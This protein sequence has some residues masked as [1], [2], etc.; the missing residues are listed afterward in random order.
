MAKPLPVGNCRI[1]GAYGPLSFEHVPPRSAF[2]SRPILRA[3][4]EEIERAEFDV[5]NVRGK[6]HQRGSGGHTL[7]IDCNQKTGRW[8]GAAF[9]DW[10]HGAVRLL[11][12]PLGVASIY[13]PFFIFP[14][15]V[16]K[17]ILCMFA[18]RT[19]GLFPDS[20]PELRTFVLDRDVRGLNPRFQVF[21]Y[22]NVSNLFRTMGVTI[23]G[24]LRTHQISKL[25][26]ISFPPFGYVLTIDSPPPDPRL[27]EITHF[28]RYKYDEWRDVWLRMPLL[29]VA[30]WIPGDYRTLSEVVEIGRRNRERDRAR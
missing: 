8:Y 29:P 30:S 23:Q 20:R 21:A 17:Q 19:E 25:S 2:N 28:A 1:C 26:E 27:V 6:I 15:R 14:L 18:S 10:A 11:D 24:N 16:F 13:C 4:I 5:Q 9:A 12:R 3:T 7:C 22:L